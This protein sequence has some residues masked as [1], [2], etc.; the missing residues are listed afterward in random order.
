[1]DESRWWQFILTEAMQ[2]TFPWTPYVRVF[3]ALNTLKGIKGFQREKYSTNII[4]IQT[5][6]MFVMWEETIIREPSADEQGD[7]PNVTSPAD[8]S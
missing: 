4:F 3:T 5:N 8:T 1:M 7:K 2:N 6:V